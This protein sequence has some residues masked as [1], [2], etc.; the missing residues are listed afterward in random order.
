MV[1]YLNSYFVI[2]LLK[3]VLNTGTPNLPGKSAIFCT[4]NKSST[5]ASMK[6]FLYGNF[7]HM[8][9]FYNFATGTILRTVL[10]VELFLGGFDQPYSI[11]LSVP[12]KNRL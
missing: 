7:I 2:E 4:L 10:V 3:T 1:F 11:R 6:I 5:Y 12:I 8:T 9:F